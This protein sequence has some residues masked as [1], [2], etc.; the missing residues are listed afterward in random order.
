MYESFKSNPELKRIL[1]AETF[2]YS[3]RILELTG[4]LEL[5]I[6]QISSLVGLTPLEYLEL[7]YA[8]L[9][10]EVKKYKRVIDILER[11]FSIINKKE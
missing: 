4:E 5:D 3:Q 8:N 10:I 11:Q 9:D 1:E 6:F 2:P 7:E